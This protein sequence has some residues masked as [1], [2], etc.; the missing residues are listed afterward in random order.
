MSPQDYSAGS[1]PYSPGDGTAAGFASPYPRT[2][3]RYWVHA[4]LFLLTLASTTVMGTAFWRDFSLNRPFYLEH[5]F[6]AFE[7][8]WRHPAAL[9]SGLPFSLVLLAILG[10]HE[11]GHYV[12]CLHYRVDAS[13]PYFLPGPPLIG[14]FGAFIRIRS[15]ILSKR[16][17]F[18]I[19][20]AGPLAGFVV[21]VPAL[22]VGLAL[23]K[24]M[25]GIAYQ[26]DVQFGMPLLLSLAERA[27][28]PGTPAANI[29]L[30]PVARAAWVGM[31]ATALN[32]LPI[33][34]LDGGHILY[35]LAGDRHR[36]LSLLFTCVLIPLAHFWPAWLVWAVILFF[37]GRRHPL[38]YDNTGVGRPR[39][40]LGWIAMLIFVLCFTLAPLTSGGL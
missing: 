32:L 31:L 5:G 23:S 15:A 24:V 38:V 9:W 6:E 11:G 18:D 27:I 37:L 36:K 13:L 22:G 40:V 20:I 25:T 8:V 33:G 3:R 10:A 30:H 17:L 19:G 4:L 14:T 1:F 39:V 2:R 35:A 34:Q 29:Y 26:G 28:F 7:A 16:V 21:L 12:A